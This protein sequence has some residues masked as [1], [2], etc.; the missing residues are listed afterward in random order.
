MTTALDLIT[1]AL[2]NAGVNGVG[3]APSAEDTSDCLA[4]LNG[5]LALWASKRW[6]VWHLLDLPL[7]STGA[8]SYTIGAGMQ[9]NCD[10]PD[11]LEAAFVRM[12]PG[13]ANPVDY[14]LSI[15]QSREDWNSVGLKSWSGMPFGVFL[16]SGYPTGTV[17]F[18]PV[19]STAYELH[20][21]VK[22][23]LIT[24]TDLTVPLAVPPE[25]F[26]ALLYNLA[27]R[28]AI[29]YQL[30]QRQDVVAL[31]VAGLAT[32]RA[33]NSQVPVLGMPPALSSR[34]TGTNPSGIASGIW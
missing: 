24:V 10:R 9:F 26:E 13:T 19:P 18:W 11:R 30:P 28:V 32:I 2:K 21:S 17:Y 31:A 20:L 3:Q 6:L 33:S 14:P 15:I 8:A 25:Y 22:A 4:A 5:M 34:R 29:M 1:L 7:Q 16:D 12:N 27:A 23:P